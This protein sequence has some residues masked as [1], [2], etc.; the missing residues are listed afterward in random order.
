MCCVGA[1]DARHSD[2]ASGANLKELWDVVDEGEDD[3]GADIDKSIETQEKKDTINIYFQL[4]PIK[5]K[6]IF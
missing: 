6:I 2:G 1:I 5:V 4:F 3:V